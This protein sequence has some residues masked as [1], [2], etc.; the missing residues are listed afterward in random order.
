MTKKKSIWSFVLACCL[1]VPAMLIMT[2][3]GKDKG[4]NTDAE[5]HTHTYSAEWTSDGT[6]HWHTATCDHADEK[7]GYGE[8]T[9]EVWTEKTPA[10]LHVDRVEQGTCTVCNKVIEQ[11]VPNTATHTY[12]TAWSKN[13]TH[14]WKESTCGHTPALKS[15]EAEHTFGNWSEKTSAGVDQNRQLS[16]KCTECEYEDILTFENTKTNGAYCMAITYVYKTKGTDGEYKVNVDVKVIRGTFETGDAVK[17]EGVGQF[18][19]DEI[20]QKGSQ[21]GTNTMDR[22]TY[23]DEVTLIISAESGDIDKVV[24]KLS[25]WLMYAPDTI[26]P[27]YNKFTATI[28]IN[29]GDVTK[30]LS[31]GTN[32]YVDFYDTGYSMSSYSL[33]LP[34]GI[35]V[36]EDG[37]SYILTITL[38]N[39]EERTI[40]AGMDFK[41]KVFVDSDYKTI[42]T[43]TI[44]SVIEN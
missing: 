20:R 44:L 4:G 18:V 32:L 3:C 17:I 13:K 16:R 22:A 24:A 19:I 33:S 31:K 27:T 5:E 39:N 37:T 38:K 34:E 40:W 26:A 41:L 21:P 28:K 9:V 11:T 25:G 10:G 36:A 35:E 8:H 42:A 7:S 1:I 23:G 6:H 2:A 14:H 29:K 43:G 12:S 30:P 15:E